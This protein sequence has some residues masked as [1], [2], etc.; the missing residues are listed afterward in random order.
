MF[1]ISSGCCQAQGLLIVSVIPALL[2]AGLRCASVCVQPL[3][4]LQAK[5]WCLSLWVLETLCPAWLL[6]CNC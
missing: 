2:G 4:L 5:H 1:I 3:G 6:M